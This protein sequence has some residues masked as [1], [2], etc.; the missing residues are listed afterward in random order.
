MSTSDLYLLFGKSVRHWSEHHNG[1]GSAP[2]VWDYLGAKYVPE[3]PIYTGSPT[4]LRKV[5]NLRRED[6]LSR[7]ELAALFFTFDNAFAPKADLG[8]IAEWFEEF[9]SLISVD[10]DFA[11][12][13]NHWGAFAAEL[14]RVKDT[15][16]DG[17]LR[18]VCITC[19]SV[20]DVWA[21]TKDFSKA[22][23]ITS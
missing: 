14:R 22:W 17:R 21:Y 10:P 9:D 15:V 13:A 18:G 19:T 20:N 5:W 2:V 16:K 3:K 7:A 11:G 4:Y 12:R 1:F 23:P 6:G 8:Q